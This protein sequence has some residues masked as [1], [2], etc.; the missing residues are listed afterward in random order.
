MLKLI[1][2]SINTSD[3]EGPAVIN[4]MHSLT[5]GVFKYLE[6]MSK[7]DLYLRINY[8]ERIQRGPALNVFDRYC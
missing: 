6:I 3:H 5:V 4:E 1:Y 8:T 2:L 7:L